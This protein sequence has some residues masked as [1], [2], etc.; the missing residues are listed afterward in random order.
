MINP[1]KIGHM[2]YSHYGIRSCIGDFI[3]E[4]PQDSVRD[5]CDLHKLKNLLGG[6]GTCFKN[7]GKLNVF[8]C[9]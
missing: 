5:F 1:S 4:V 2:N 3:P 8:I 9:S 7:P 6:W